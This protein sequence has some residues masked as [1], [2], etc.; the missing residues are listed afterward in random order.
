MMSMQK[1]FDIAHAAGT[2]PPKAAII[3]TAA[4]EQPQCTAWLHHLLAHVQASG[5]NGE[6][7]KELDAYTKAAALTSWAAARSTS[8]PSPASSSFAAAAAM[9]R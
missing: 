9:H 2:A 6:L 7:L 8:H 4:A 5:G 1:A 3:A